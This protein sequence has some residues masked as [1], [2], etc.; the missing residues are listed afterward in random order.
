[1]LKVYRLKVDEFR[2]TSP[3]FYA[4]LVKYPRILRY[5]N[6]ENQRVRGENIKFLER[7]V[8][9]GYFRDDVNYELA[10]R[11]FDA[12]G[13][14]IMAQRLYQYYSIEDIFNNLVFVSLRGFC[15]KKGE[16]ALERFTHYIYIGE[17]KK[18]T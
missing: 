6:R 5:L 13:R 14:Y 15:T 8:N 3:A 1:M 2:M 7:G 10:S 17:L 9:E 16:E 12:L 18:K 11:L 4:D